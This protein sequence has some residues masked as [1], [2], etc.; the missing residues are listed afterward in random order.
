MFDGQRHSCGIGVCLAGAELSIKSV[1]CQL[2]FGCNKL[3]ACA[4]GKTM[5]VASQ[6]PNA[7]LGIDLIHDFAV[8]IR[9]EYKAYLEFIGG[10][11]GGAKHAVQHDQ[12]VHQ[13]PRNTLNLTSISLANACPLATIP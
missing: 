13:L 4:T 8:V 7:N 5:F 6:R 10:I 11:I 9:Q 1:G 12:W 3:P 2:L